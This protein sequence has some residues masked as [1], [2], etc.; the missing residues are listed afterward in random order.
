MSAR[1]QANYGGGVAAGICR[2][3]VATPPVYLSLSLSFDPADTRRLLGEEGVETETTELPLALLV[4][5]GRVHESRCIQESRCRIQDLSSQCVVPLLEIEPRHSFLDLCAA[6]GGKTFQAIDVLGDSRNVVAADR[7]L[8]RLRTLQGLAAGR[9]SGPGQA[10]QVDCVALD[11][12]RPLPFRKTFDR[13]L[14]DAPCTG[15]GTLARN[16]EIKWRLRPEDITDLAAKQRAILG[17]ALDHLA[18]SGILVYSTC[19]LEPEENQEVIEAVRKERPSFELGAYFQRVSGRE[20]GD[21][22]FACQIRRR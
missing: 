17:H 8:H 2:S 3:G 19:S 5:R 14:V 11:A 13:I 16:P 10:R 15:T 18:P 9:P 20:P 6:P 4:T 22:F 21:G 7:H 1:W 12:Q